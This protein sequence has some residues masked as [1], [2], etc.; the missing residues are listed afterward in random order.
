TP[1]PGQNGQDLTIEWSGFRPFNV[2]NMARNGA[3]VR[4]VN[5]GKSFNQQLSTDLQRHLGSAAKNA[6]NKELKNVGASV[7]YKLRDKT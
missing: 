4:A 5:S 2:E 1:F 6:N 3:D 7:Q